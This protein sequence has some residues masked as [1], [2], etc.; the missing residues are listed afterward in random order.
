M[1]DI[2]HN[3]ADISKIKQKLGFLPK[4]DFAAGISNFVDWVNT[5]SVEQDNYEKSIDEMKKRGLYK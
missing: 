1:G 2:R 4:Y 5:Q 3:F